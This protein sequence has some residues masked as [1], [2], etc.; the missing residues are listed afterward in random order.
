MSQ[1]DF[2]YSDL[3][4]RV[5]KKLYETKQFGEDVIDL[6]IKGSKIINYDEK[7]IDIIAKNYAAFSIMLD[8]NNNRI[9]KECLEEVLEQPVAELRIFQEDNLSPKSPLIQNDF[10]DLN[11]EEE[12]RFDTFC[13]GKSNS[14]AHAAAITVANN[15]GTFYNPLFIYGN[16]GIGK[17][18]LLNA[19][20]NY[21]LNTFSNKRIGYISGTGFVEALSKA[22][23]ENTIDEFKEAF[24]SLDLLL[25]DDIQFISN[26]AKTQEVFFTIF[27]TLVNNRKQICIT[28]DCAPNEIHGIEERI[29]SRFNR[30][31]TVNIESPEFETRIA[32]LKAKLAN[33]VSEK[34]DEEVFTY[35]A[36][37][38]SKDVRELEGAITR[39]YFY[40]IQFKGNEDHISLNLAIE[41]FK[42]Q[43]QDNRNELSVAKIKKTVADYY[44]L[45]TKQLTS[46]TRTKNIAIPRH[47]AM[48]L[49]RNILDVPYKEIGN[50]FGNRDHSTVINACEKV[51]SLIKTDQN[52]SKAIDEIKARMN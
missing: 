2:Y 23:K 42:D 33:I 1:I 40:Y 12:Q 24:Y 34:V 26:K 27:N 29:I 31:L 7:G 13:I 18:H 46:S 4:S 16:S 51:E 36:T 5:L 35:M 50:E 47:I 14:Q 25:V 6:Y 17:S 45:T 37:N 52:Y 20:G 48:Y 49:C 10:F 19:I 22:L 30:G 39:L 43:I 8:P 15:L 3:W 9:I 28:A 41:A 38:F 21:V 11:I 44:N 32:I